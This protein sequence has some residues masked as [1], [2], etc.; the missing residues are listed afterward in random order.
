MVYRK[1]FGQWKIK[2]ADF[3]ISVALGEIEKST[4]D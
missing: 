1:S 2:L 3:G 4:I